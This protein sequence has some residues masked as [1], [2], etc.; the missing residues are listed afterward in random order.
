MYEWSD[1][2]HFLSIHRTGNLSA[3]ARELAVNQTTVGRHL[4]QLE[5]ALGTRLFDRRSDGFVLTSAGHELLPIAERVEAEAL[6][7]ERLTKGRDRKTEGLVRITTTEAL[8]SRYLMPRLVSFRDR[9]PGVRID[10]QTAFRALNL[11]RHEADVALR[12]LPTTQSS[13]LVRKAGAIAFAVYA[14]RGYV[15]RRGT[16]RTRA[17]LAKHVLLGFDE[18]LDGAAESKWMAASTGGRPYVIRSNSTN[19]LLAG[20]CA[21]LG[22]AILPCFAADREDGVV[23]VLD[24]ATVV[25]RDLWLVVHKD[26][27]RVPRVR[28]VMKYLADQVRADAALLLGR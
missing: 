21:D 5:E 15:E 4:G 2:R 22:L 18:S 1:L 26:M 19:T 25:T 17:D 13:L 24:G 14:G 7:L 6:A 27:A 9:Y 8:G 16:P 28:V 23:R 20:V 11:T 10:I 3:A 12:I